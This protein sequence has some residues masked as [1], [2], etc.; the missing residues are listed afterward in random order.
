MRERTLLRRTTAR[1]TPSAAGHLFRRVELAPVFESLRQ[2]PNIWCGAEFG[3]IFFAPLRYGFRTVPCTVA[4]ADT[5]S[6]MARLHLFACR[7]ITNRPWP[8]TENQQKVGQIPDVAAGGGLMWTIRQLRSFTPS[9]VLMPAYVPML[10]KGLESA[11][12]E[13]T[14]GVRLLPTNRSS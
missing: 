3:I 12:I 9:G 2:A 4:T 14:P 8:R 10:R 1:A 11:V 7:L 13:I 6:Q 5:L